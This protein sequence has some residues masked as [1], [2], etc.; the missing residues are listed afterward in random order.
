MGKGEAL[1][2]EYPLHWAVFRR[3]YEELLELLNENAVIDIDKVDCRG[4]TPLMLAVTLGHSECAR[5]LLEKGADAT[6]QNADMWSLSHEAIC[7]GDAEMLKIILKF[8]DFQ[9]SVNLNRAVEKLLK[10]LKETSD[11]Y[12]EMSWE[13]SSWLPF[14]SKMCPSDTYKI[15]KC[16]SDVRIDTTLVGFDSGSSWKR[17]NQSFI[18][19]F[20][21]DNQIQFLIIDHDLKTVIAKFI[22]SA[23]KEKLEEFEPT[24]ESVY[25][26]MCAPVETTY[27]DI[28]K[29]GFERSKT[30]GFRSWFSSCDGVESVN[31]YDCKI[32]AASNVE[33]VTKQRVEHLLEEDKERF[34]QE[35]NNDSLSK[36]LKLIEKTEDYTPEMKRTGNDV[37]CGLTPRQYLD[38]DF[39][40]NDRDIGHPKQVK[41][42]CN[43][44]KATLWLCDQFPLSLQEQIL[45]IVDLMAVS[46]A[47]FARLKNFIQLQLPAGFPVKIEV[48]LFHLVS[49]RITFSN[50]NK[51]GPYVKLN[52]ADNAIVFAANTFDI[53]A[54]YRVTET[55]DDFAGLYAD[56]YAYVDSNQ[57]MN[58]YTPDEL[59]LQYALEQ[60]LLDTPNY[61][62][63]ESDRNS[64]VYDESLQEMDPELAMAIAESLRMARSDGRGDSPSSSSLNTDEELNRVLQSSKREE[65]ERIRLQLQEDDDLKRALELSLIEK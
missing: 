13:F 55:Q 58:R 26:R 34:R 15:Y 27:V 57:H 1:K 63:N 39:P 23:V 12:A 44:F 36:V 51:P 7:S 19:R 50:I 52:E 14:V 53:P 5:A 21:S 49:A 3:D 28:E 62:S 56:R 47:H 8:R 61:H 32:F 30:G 65:E 24:E 22:S 64:V 45:P 4:R 25:S 18:F 20:T 54:N 17:G 40:M 2:N 46:N 29:I 10:L 60:S 48:P 33:I 6:V 16:G 38:K 31:G 35:E 37:Y 11:F 41:R 43:S 9:R 59:Y 42:K